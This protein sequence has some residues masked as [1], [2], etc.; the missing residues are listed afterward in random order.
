[1]LF[2]LTSLTATRLLIFALVCAAVGTWFER[3][4]KAALRKI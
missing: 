2:G 4:Y 1:M 3:L